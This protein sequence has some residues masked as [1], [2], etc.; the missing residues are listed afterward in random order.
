MMRDLF[1]SSH[2]LAGVEGLEFNRRLS[3]GEV[4][5]FEASRNETSYI[6]ATSQ[7]TA[8]RKNP[9]STF[10]SKKVF[11]YTDVNNRSEIISRFRA[12]KFAPK[13]P[14][15]GVKIMHELVTI[16]SKIKDGDAV[17]PPVDSS[18]IK[19]IVEDGRIEDIV[20][21]PLKKGRRKIHEQQKKP[22]NLYA[23]IEWPGGRRTRTE[24]VSITRES[25]S[26][27]SI[28]DVLFGDFNDRKELGVQYNVINF[29]R[30]KPKKP[31]NRW[32]SFARA[33]DNVASGRSQEYYALSY[34]RIRFTPA[35]CLTD[36][37]KYLS[38]K[39]KEAQVKIMP[40]KS[41]NLLNRVTS[42]QE[43]AAIQSEEMSSE[44]IGVEEELKAVV[45]AV[46]P[47]MHPSVA[48]M[49]YKRYG[50][51]PSWYSVGRSSASEILATRYNSARHL[52]PHIIALISQRC[53]EFL[54]TRSNTILDEFR[55]QQDLLE[56]YRPWYSFVTRRFQ[57]KKRHH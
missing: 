40:K 18:S 48:I 24:K 51:C 52:P 38:F 50:E 54:D 16:G 45:P 30:G 44:V 25:G 42:A 56:K 31:F 29:M 17:E 41:F 6:P 37:S 57:R 33:P 28:L 35:D 49:R 19:A 1:N 7:K 21:A 27:F 11:I 3:L 55:D 53:P 46:R 26:P 12:G 14:V 13:R 4:E 32:V 9:S 22:G 47:L 23:E 15:N 5:D 20:V 43:T 34:D 2:F 36:I 39:V 8:Y 10:V